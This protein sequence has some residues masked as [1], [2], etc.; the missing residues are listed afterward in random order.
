[1]FSKCTESFSAHVV[2]C[3][4][5]ESMVEDSQTPLVWLEQVGKR[6]ESEAR[7]PFQHLSIYIASRQ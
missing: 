1:M 7:E 4:K 6:R 5:E 2:L 3:T